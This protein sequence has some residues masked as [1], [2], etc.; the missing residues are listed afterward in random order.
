ME[1]AAL[2]DVPSAA[3]VPLA[4]VVGLVIGSFLNVVIHRVPAGESVVRPPSACPEC[5]TVIRA[6]HN[7]PVLG[8]LLLRG[9][10][11]DCATPISVRYPLVEVGTAAA[12]VVVALRFRDDLAVLPAFLDFAA[13]G[14]VLTAID[15]DVRR[16]PNVIVLPTYP[17]LAVLLAVG[18]DSDALLR[19][20][21]GAGGVFAAFF[22][23]AMLV[24][25]GLGFGDVKLA[26]LIGGMTAYLS[27]GTLLV[28]VFGGFLLGALA[29]VMLL[30]GG[31]ADRR[32]AV[33]FGPFL[34]L[35]AWTSILGAHHFGD[36]YLSAVLG[37]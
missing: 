16:L 12:F 29:G 25:G 28:G 14:I 35:G 21:L 22:L 9:A 3:L 19:A 5:G 32:S 7:I 6:R 24:P 15:L 36:V 30:A 31:R 4:A 17:A 18:W 26:G 27:W 23:L 13:V 11:A 37:V 2:N 34:V 1:P 10:C 8:W 20:L 33:P